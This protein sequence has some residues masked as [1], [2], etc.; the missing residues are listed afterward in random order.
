MMRL[1]NYFLKYLKSKYMNIIRIDESGS[2]FDHMVGIGF[3]SRPKFG[4]FGD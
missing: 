2:I 4:S 3:G 1:V